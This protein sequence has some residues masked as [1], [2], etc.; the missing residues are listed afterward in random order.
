MPGRGRTVAKFVGV[1]DDRTTLIAAEGMLRLERSR[2][3][4]LWCG[5]RVARGVCVCEEGRRQ[6]GMLSGSGEDVRTTD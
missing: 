4:G 1:N 5:V 2:I 3:K 6:R